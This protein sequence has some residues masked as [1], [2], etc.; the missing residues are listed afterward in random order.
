MVPHTREE[1]SV[2]PEEPF[3]TKLRP[4]DDSGIALK[5]LTGN[6]SDLTFYGST[7]A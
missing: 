7:P 3:A 4:E 5:N 6:R 2:T 1:P